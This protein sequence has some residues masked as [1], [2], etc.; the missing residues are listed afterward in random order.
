MSNHFFSSNRGLGLKP[1]EIHPATTSTTADDMELR[2]ADGAN[3]TRLDV[4]HFLD[5]VRTWFNSHQNTTVPPL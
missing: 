4:N 2:I 1:S 3:L 5:R